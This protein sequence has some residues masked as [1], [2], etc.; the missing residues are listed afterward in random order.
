MEAGP[1]VLAAMMPLSVLVCTVVS[2]GDLTL[3]DTLLL[4]AL[5]YEITLSLLISVSKNISDGDSSGL[6][7]LFSASRI[8]QA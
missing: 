6:L 5:R 7:H 2:L 1:T 8:A 4:V 3:R